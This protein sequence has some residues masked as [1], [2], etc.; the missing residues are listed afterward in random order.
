VVSPLSGRER[1]FKLTPDALDEAITERT[2]L[3]IINSPCNPTGADYSRGELE[4]LAEVMVKRDI[5]AVSDE[6]YERIVF[7]GAQQASLAGLSDEMY[8]RTITVNGHS[9]SYR[10]TG[11]RIGYAAGDAEVIAAAGRVQSQSTSNPCT[12]SQW[13]AIEALTGDQASIGEMV[14]EFTARRDE[15]VARLNGIDGVECP[16]P[17]GAFYVF[18]DVSGLLGR[19]IGSGEPADTVELAKLCLEEAKV[20]LL[21]GEAFGAPG[22][23]R[24]SYVTDV[25]TIRE[26]VA[27][28][29][30]LFGGK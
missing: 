29:A 23:L 3:V 15:I 12:P 5:Y 27:R 9:K 24:I 18:P 26:A 30:K 1:G 20:A 6:I 21:P 4:G 8:A 7:D 17:G 19:R 14:R 28:L 22:Y 10:M 11:W 16:A 25:E 2:R 13:A